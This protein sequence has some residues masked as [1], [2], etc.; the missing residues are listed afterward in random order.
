MMGFFGKLF[1]IAS[2][3]L[4][5]FVSGL[6]LLERFDVDVNAWLRGIPPVIS[7]L[8]E[9]YGDWVD[10]F[11]GERLADSDGRAPR[12]VQR[13]RATETAP[14]AVTDAISP[15]SVPV[16]GSSA[17]MLISAGIAALMVLILAFMSRRL[18]RRA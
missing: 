4:G 11:A 14:G 3:A 16:Q 5:L 18:F 6:D 2:A 9:S 7:T 8:P 1:V 17:P 12:A 10:R 15:P 13:L